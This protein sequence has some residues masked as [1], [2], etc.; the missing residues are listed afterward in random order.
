MNFTNLETV[1]VSGLYTDRAVSLAYMFTNCEK[2]T[3]IIG[4]GDLN[5]DRVENMSSMF[6]RYGFFILM[7]LILGNIPAI[8]IGPLS[9]GLINSFVKFYQLFSFR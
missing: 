7:L 3:E 1:D 4:L 2:L 8:V 6:E 5:T 9:E